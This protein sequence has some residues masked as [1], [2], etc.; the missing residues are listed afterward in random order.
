MR[1]VIDAGLDADAQELVRDIAGDLCREIAMKDVYR[2][3]KQGGANHS[4]QE[5]DAAVKA[6]PCIFIIVMPAT[7]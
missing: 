6:K 2:P 4:K 5:C 3:I 7:Q 1:I